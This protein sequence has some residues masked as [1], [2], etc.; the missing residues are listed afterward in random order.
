MA[1]SQNGLTEQLLG[2][3]DS[4]T[5]LFNNSSMETDIENNEPVLF[6]NSSY[7]LND[8]FKR[9]MNDKKDVFSILSLNCQSLNAKFDELNAYLKIFNDDEYK[10]CAICLQ[11]TWLT[12]DSDLSML[13]I[14]GY[15]LISVGKSSSAHGG[16]AIYLH[17]SFSFRISDCCINSNIFDMQ[18][19]EILIENGSNEPQTLVL[20]NIYRPPRPNSENINTFINE[21]ELLTTKLLNYKHVVLTG[22]FNLDLLKFKENNLINSFLESLMSSSFIP[23]IVLPTWITHRKGTLIDIF[24]VKISQEYS[25]TTSGILLNCMSDHLPYFTFLDYLSFSKSNAKFIKLMPSFTDSATKMKS[26]L[27]KADTVENLQNINGNDSN[28][29]YKKFSDITTPLMNKHFIVKRVRYDKR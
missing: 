4:L 1:D 28:E 13:Q 15:H 6:Q 16:V 3:T 25:N 7:Y 17:D 5:D 27:N 9:L 8:T 18:F 11:E 26:D 19:I 29:S 10:I 23:K 22:D 20:G 2:N 24:F 14:E 21:I 12:A